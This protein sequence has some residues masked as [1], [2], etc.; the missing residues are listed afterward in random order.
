[1]GFSTGK[2]IISLLTFNSEF[3]IPIKAWI[4]VAPYA[5]APGSEHIFSNA[6]A[7]PMNT[8]KEK[9][10]TSKISHL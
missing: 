8:A 7:E 3:D 6:L 5:A 1:M 4:F 2:A 10:I 9:S